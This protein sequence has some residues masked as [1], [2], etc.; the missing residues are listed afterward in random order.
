VA[1]VLPMKYHSLLALLVVGIPGPAWAWGDLGHKIICEIALR[2]VAP[3]TRTEIQNL[4]QADPDYA[5]F[6]DACTWPDHPRKRAAEHFLNLPRDSAGL[7][8]E[9]CGDSSTCVVTAIRKDAATLASKTVTTAD[10][11]AALKYLGHWVGDVH[12]PLHVS[13]ADDR[14]GNDTHISGECGQ[15]LHSS[16]DTCLVI[17]AV[18]DDVDKA[19][20]YLMKAVTPATAA[21]WT[22]STPMDWANESF[23][24]AERPE[25]KYCSR[26]TTTCVRQAG[27][28]RIDRAYIEANA[29]VIR[30]RLQ[31]AGI[32]LS[33]LLDAA[34]AN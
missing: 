2:S 3:S 6:A 24:V 30:E 34:L 1:N 17:R 28:I 23:A 11:L 15:N 14:G 31:Q 9:G 8:T 7:T 12:Q 27:S 20:T 18:G 22:A 10:R 19:A 4:M 26:E 21:R 16:W 25:T 32:R 5:S 29:P 33:R 13:F